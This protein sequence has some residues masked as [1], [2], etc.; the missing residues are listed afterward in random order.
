MS[1]KRMPLCDPRTVA[2]DI[3]GVLDILFPRLSG[4]LVASLNKR[5]FWFPQIKAIPDAMIAESSMR[6]SMLFELSVAHAE[7]LL[8]GEG[9]ADWQA[10]LHIAVE[11]QRRHYDAQLPRSLTSLDIQL[12]RWATKNLF[13]MLESVTDQYPLHKLQLRPKIP[14]LG[15]ICSGEGDFALGPILVEVK[16][17]DRNFVA[18][19]FRQ[20]LIYW[21]LK[22]AE[23]LER[24]ED[25]WSDCLLINPRRNAA[26]AVNF[27]Y[28]IRSAATVPSRVELY[29]LLRS[30]V[31]SDI[32]QRQ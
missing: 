22:Y 1:R 28:L 20:I 13:K 18:G 3:P 31:G 2:R 4:G 11:R 23:S 19:D 15:W 29:E 9:D 14:G 6:P 25:V 16:H 10:S 27:D 24:D 8:N 26:L 21:L 5:I 12:A 17:T 7:R 32:D 30:V